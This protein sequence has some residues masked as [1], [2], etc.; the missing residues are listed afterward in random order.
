MKQTLKEFI[1]CH[2]VRVRPKDKPW[3]T[4][5]LRALIRK[6]NRLCRRFK[7]SRNPCHYQVYKKIRNAVV[8]PNRK[9]M[10]D[11]ANSVDNNLQ[12]KLMTQKYGGAMSKLFLLSNQS[13]LSLS[14]ILKKL[15]LLII[16]SRN[17]VFHWIQIKNSQTS[18][19]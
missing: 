6:R 13:I 12:Q 1:P 9:C 8:S 16:I 3:V 10:S 14:L 15:V 4:T 7:Q 2:I 5:Q 17:N 19:I 18:A 11:Y